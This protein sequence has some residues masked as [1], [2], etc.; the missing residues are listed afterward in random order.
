MPDL[1]DSSVGVEEGRNIRTYTQRCCNDYMWG[2]RIE[3]RATNHD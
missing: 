3:I 1:V 2:R